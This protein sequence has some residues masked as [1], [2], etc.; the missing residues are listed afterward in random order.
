MIP[1]NA[2]WIQ[3][4]VKA[5]EPDQNQVTCENG[6]KITYDYLVVAAGIQLDWEKIKGLKE[7]IGTRGICSNYLY[8]LAPYTWETL[9]KFGKGKAVFTSPN[10]PIKCGG[11]PQKTMYLATD[12][13]R[14]NGR[15]KQSEVHFYPAGGVIFGVEK[16]AEVLKKVIERYGITLLISYTT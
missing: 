6:S 4:K 9:Q 5:F 14:K 13:L 1:A 10:T 8:S 16:Y 11:A 15:L 7:S 3:E 12:Y 2:S